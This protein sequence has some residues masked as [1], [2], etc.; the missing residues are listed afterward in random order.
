M[1]KLLLLLVVCAAL[2][3]VPAALA[4][5]HSLTGAYYT[6]NNYPRIGTDQVTL[7][8]FVAG[9]PNSGAPYD[10]TDIVTCDNGFVGSADYYDTKGIDTFTTGAGNCTAVLSYAHGNKTDVFLDSVSFTVPG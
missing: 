2:V 6:Q 4:S 7:I 3:A 10:I 5:G 1:K 8:Y 9:F